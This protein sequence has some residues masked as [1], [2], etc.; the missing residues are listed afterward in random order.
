MLTEVSGKLLLREHGCV[1]SWSPR[2]AINIVQ[3][4]F[5]EEPVSEQ[6]RSKT[7]NSKTNGLSLVNGRSDACCDWKKA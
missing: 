4:M 1:V 2:K 3:Y 7:K 6:I 5:L